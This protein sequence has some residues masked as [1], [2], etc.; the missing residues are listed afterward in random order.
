[1]IARARQLA[2]F[3]AIVA[4]LAMPAA[5]QRAVSPDPGAIAAAKE[6]MIVL[7]VEKQMDVMLGQMIPQMAAMIKQMRPENA[8]EID[9]VF[10]MMG[11][12]FGERKQEMIDLVAPLY[13]EHLSAAEMNAVSSFFKSETGRKFVT[14][15]P[16]IMQKSMQ[17]GQAWGQRLGAEIQGE[18]IRELKNK[19]IDL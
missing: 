14:A 9:E 17:V 11:K 15:Q 10:A 3:A 5:A 4:I 1:M 2:A 7:G 12:R 6:L 8:R 16:E 13:A 18:V 19:G